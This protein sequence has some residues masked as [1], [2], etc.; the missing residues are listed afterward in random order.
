MN[1][2]ATLL[3]QFITFGIFVFVMVK[4]VW[5][6]I[7]GALRARQHKIADG[8]EAAE[9]GVRDLEQAKAESAKLNKQAREQAAILAA[10][11]NKR[12]VTIVEEAKAQARSEHDRIVAAAHDEIEQEKHRLREALRSEV[13]AIAVAGAGRILEREID[14]K[15]HAELLDKLA[16]EL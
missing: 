5:P 9:Q 1:F 7:M 13:A 14:D 2:N 15:A 16:A 3:G 6:P 12:G 4:F 8:L 10:E 11:A